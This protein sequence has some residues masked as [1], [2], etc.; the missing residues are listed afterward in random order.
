MTARQRPGADGMRVV[1]IGGAGFVGRH[2]VRRLLEAGHEVQSLDR[3][4]PAVRLPGER[5]ALADLAASGGPE[6]GAASCGRVDAV[7]WLAALIRQEKDVDESA[8]EDLRVMVEAPLLFLQRLDPAP[9]VLVHASSIQVYGRPHRLPVDENHPTEPFKPYGVAK[10]CAEQYL[11]VACRA[12]GV[13]LSNLRLAF[14]HGPGQHPG[15]VIPRF[16]ACVARGESPVVHGGGDSVRDDIHVDDVARAFELAIACRA[17]GCFNVATGK[18]RTLREVAL[19]ACSLAETRQLAPRHV[20]R[21][22]DW[23]DRWFAV[24]RARE[25][26]GF[27]ASLSLEEGLARTWQSRREDGSP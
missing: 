23:I 27:E 3:N 20:Q 15:N 4:A 19:A 21:G 13:A 5:F 2:V 1:V 6:A 10:L 25:V 18:P 16:L 11:D 8:A 12:R 14:V 26:L 22:S 24:D 9:A 17:T 7:V